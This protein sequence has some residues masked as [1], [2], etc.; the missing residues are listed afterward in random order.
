MATWNLNNTTHHVL[1]CNGSSC[2]HVGAEDLT[3]EIRR[4]IS[5]RGL[6]DRIHTTRTRC[7]GRCHDKCV[8]INYP[9]GHWYK[10]LLPEDAP[11]FIDSLLDNEDHT[12]KISHSYNGQGFERSPDVATGIS[13]NREKVNKMSK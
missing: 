13:K 11:L 3:Q 12:G 7:N 9:Q 4:E 1:I 2:T 5:E 6:D 8:V 10:D